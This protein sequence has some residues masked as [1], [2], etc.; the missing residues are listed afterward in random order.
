[1]PRKPR[2]V[3][4]L[5]VLGDALDVAVAGWDQVVP[6]LVVAA[7]DGARAAPDPGPRCLVLADTFW[8][9]PSP[10]AIQPLLQAA[11]PISR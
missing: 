7:A 4:E 6:S 10:T 3:G 9:T 1:M 8:G 11:D 2:D 5:L